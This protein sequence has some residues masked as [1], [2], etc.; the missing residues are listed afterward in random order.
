MH[1]FFLPSADPEVGIPSHPSTHPPIH[2]LTHPPIH[3]STHPSIHPPFYPSKHPSTQIRGITELIPGLNRLSIWTS[4]DRCCWRLLL[5]RP[6]GHSGVKMLDARGSI[7]EHFVQFFGMGLD[8]RIDDRLID[9]LNDW[10]MVRML[11]WLMDGTSDWL[12]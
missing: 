3:P 5:I 8:P 7:S 9:W 11:E 4:V 6:Y 10:W 1:Y 2:P 12:I